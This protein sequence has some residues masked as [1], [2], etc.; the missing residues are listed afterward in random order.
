VPLFTYDGTHLPPLRVLIHSL[1]KGM[2]FRGGK[3]CCVRRNVSKHR[4]CVF[5]VQR[6][7]A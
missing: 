4:I 7:A 1:I 5:T 6:P 3:K 2:K